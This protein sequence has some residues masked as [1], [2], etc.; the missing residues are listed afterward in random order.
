MALT[1]E[2]GKNLK[3]LHTMHLEAKAQYYCQLQKSE[4]LP[5]LLDD[6]PRFEKVYWLG[7][8]SNT[9]FLGDVEGLVVSIG[10]QKWR[11]LEDNPE[12]ILLAVEAGLPWQDLIAL[13]IEKG[14]YGLENLVAIPGSVGAAPVQNIGAYGVEVGDLIAWVEIIDLKKGEKKQI[15]SQDCQFGYRQS[16]FQTKPEWLIVEVIFHLKKKFEPQLRYGPLAVWG[17]KE[18]NQGALT[19]QTLATYIASIRAS[20]L[21]KPK[22]LGNSGSFFHNPIVADQEAFLLKEKFPNLPLYPVGKDRSKLAAGWLIDSLGL[23]GF[24]VG[25]V[26]IH[27]CQALVIVNLGNGTAEE[28][29]DLIKII[30]DA[31]FYQFGIHLHIEPKLVGTVN[32]AEKR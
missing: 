18:E 19:A 26:A 7:K 8:G 22:K 23:K 31:V 24:R 30:Q 10:W 20:K 9:V 21:P 28:L 3:F 32:S 16:I 6:L 13:S 17:R 12:N 27:T 29:L 4:E 14:W 2:Q 5:Q 15:S 25:G 11:I 1:Y